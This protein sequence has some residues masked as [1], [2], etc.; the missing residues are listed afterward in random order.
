MND[1]WRCAPECLFAWGPED[2]HEAAPDF[3]PFAS[4]PGFTG[5]TKSNLVAPVCVRQPS[6]S[7]SWTAS[8]A[9]QWHSG[10]H[11]RALLVLRAGTEKP[12]LDGVFQI[13]SAKAFPRG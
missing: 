11:P 2:G 10:P 13:A 6:N 7:P 1:S 8:G 5:L 12:H 3:L 9:A 4:L